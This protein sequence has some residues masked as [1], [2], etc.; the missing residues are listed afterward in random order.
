MAGE[1]IAQAISDI[2]KQFPNMEGLDNE[3]ETKQFVIGEDPG[4]LGLES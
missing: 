1:T 4:R 3:E 2:R